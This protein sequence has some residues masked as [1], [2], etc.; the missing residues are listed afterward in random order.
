[1]ILRG[2]LRLAAAAEVHVGGDMADEDALVE[3]GV[4]N[5]LADLIV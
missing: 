1:M 3:V 4:I 5:A 2:W